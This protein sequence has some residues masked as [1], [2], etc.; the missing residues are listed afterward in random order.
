MNGNPNPAHDQIKDLF[1]KQHASNERLDYFMCGVAGALFAYTGQTFAPEK[2]SFYACIVT[3]VSLLLLSLSFYCA[4]R[5]IQSQNSVTR[6]NRMEI[7]TCNLIK[8]MFE[9]IVEFENNESR[10]LRGTITNEMGEPYTL[11]RLKAEK[12]TEENSL[13][14]IRENILADRSLY[15]KYGVERDASLIIG[16]VAILAAKILQW[17]WH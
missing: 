4:Y 6:G 17:L 5:R 11:D 16:F 2:L 9:R 8:T 7:E 1:T 3:I 12:K 14:E 10:G 13:I 15:I